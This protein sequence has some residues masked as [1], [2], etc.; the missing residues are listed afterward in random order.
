[1]AVDPAGGGTTDPS[2][3]VHVYSEDE[4]VD[5]TATPNAGYEF[6]HW[7]GDV[8]DPNAAS[9]TVTMDGDKTV[10][11]HFVPAGEPTCVTIQRGT[12]GEVA[13]G[14]IWEARPTEN[15]FTGSDFRSGFWSSGETR[16]LLHFDLDVLPEDAVVQSATLG[17]NQQPPGTGETVHVHRIT[18][19]WSEGGPT[20]ASFADSYDAF[21]WASFVSVGGDVTTDVTDLVAAWAG[22]SQP[23]Y[24]MMLINSPTSDNDR[25]ISSDYSRVS[26]RPRLEVCYFA[27]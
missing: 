15:N 19:A 18:A 12:L 27:P 9:T 10:T 22:G 13:D 8:A 14:F 6:D 1:M 21:T 7:T 16:A 24:G 26:M 20:W 4:V 17:L 25:Y 2:V 3:G 11:A 23:N 5:I